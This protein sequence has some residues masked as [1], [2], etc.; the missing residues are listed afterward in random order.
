MNHSLLRKI[1]G[2]VVVI[3]LVGALVYSF[4][5]KP[6]EVDLAKVERGSLRVTVDEDGKTRIRERYVVS[7]PLA[8]ELLRIVLEAGDTVTAGETLLATIEPA[9]P[10]LLDPRTLQEVGARVRAKEAAVLRAAA[11]LERTRS[12][13]ELAESNLAIERELFDNRSI[14]AQELDGY[15]ATYEIRSAEFRA[16]RYTQ[17]ISQFELEQ[18]KAA[19]VR[20]QPPDNGNSEDWRFLIHAPTDGAVLRIFEESASVVT[21]GTPLLELG[22]PLDLEVEVDVLSSDAVKIQPGAMVWFEQWGGDEPLPGRVRVV[23]PSAFTKIS[24]LGVEEQR[25]NVIIDLLAPRD[26]RLSLGDAFRVEA[27]IVVW[28]SEDVLKVPTSALFR[29][30]D[31][32]A[33]FLIENERAVLHAVRIGHLNGLFAE[34]LEGISEGDEI[35]LHPSDRVDNDTRIRRRSA[36][37]SRKS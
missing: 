5:P 24:A 32:W 13:L 21:A 22:D 18:A 35:V 14:S 28:E 16:A 8:G 2:L 36:N 9:D 30:Q 7:S 10:S 31:Q 34:V 15:E 33:L 1:I 19:L 37:G 26:D 29:H 3:A 12:A 6:V 20:S 4:L 27:R 23:E 17:E 11:E 25:V